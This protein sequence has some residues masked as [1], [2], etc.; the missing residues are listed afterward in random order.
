[1]TMAS[2][3]GFRVKLPRLPR[4]M[5]RLAV[6]GPSMWETWLTR[7]PPTLSLPNFTVG[8]P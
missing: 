5:V 7:M 3:S 6:F 1:M 4:V 8:S 2:V